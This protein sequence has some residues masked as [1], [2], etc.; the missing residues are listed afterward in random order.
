MTSVF[1]L[2]TSVNILLLTKVASEVL[3]VRTLIYLF[4]GDTIQLIMAGLTVTIIIIC[5]I[6]IAII[7]NSRI[8]KKQLQYSRGE[9]RGPP[10]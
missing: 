5:I 2:I 1:N 6:I 3:G 10:S 7:E 4:G 9:D 8:S